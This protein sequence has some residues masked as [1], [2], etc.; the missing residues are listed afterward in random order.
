MSRWHGI[1]ATPLTDAGTYQFLEA[2]R[3]NLEYLRTRS[4]AS[5]AASGLVSIA[6]FGGVGDGSTIN[7]A[8]FQAAEASVYD[9]IY[10]PHGTYQCSAI[11][12]SQLTKGYWG[13]GNILL[14][15]GTAMPGNVSYLATDP[16][17]WPVQGTTGWFRGESKFGRGEWKIIGPGIRESLTDR[18]FEQT[19]IPH[20]VWFDIYSGHSGADARL[21]AP[22]STGSNVIT[23]T[24][25]HAGMVGKTCVLLAA[26]DV[27]IL[28]TRT[29]VSV[30]P[31][32]ITLDSPPSDNW[33]VNTV[34]STARRTWHGH[35]YVRVRHYGGGDGYGHIVRMQIGYQKTPGQTH[36]FDAAT[37]GQYG[38]DVFF[39]TG[40]S[41]T[42]ATGWE[43]QY[44]D[45]GND[46]A[47]IGQVDS[48]IRDNDTAANGQVWHALYLKSE[49]TKPSDAVLAAAGKWRTVI[50][51]VRADL[52]NFDAPG[53]NANV[54]M[55]MA[56]GQRFVW[57]STA[58]LSGRTGSEEWGAY[59]GNVLGD[60]FLETGN[61]GVSDFIALR[62]N[63][64][65]PDDGRLRI[66]PFAVQANVPILSASYIQAAREII[67]GT[68]SP[69]FIFG[70]GSGVYVWWDGTNIR[71]TK[72]NGASS[73]VIV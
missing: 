23:V 40:S 55:N 34:V 25:T 4:S 57:G 73:V 17:K 33:P 54:V 63:R 6:D 24:G 72:D 39:L 70:P 48:F 62:F 43:S 42:Y 26:I 49:G 41:G 69:Y 19:A 53:D 44:H 31:T 2:V 20:S 5:V 58:S 22:A 71:A 65:A 66:R 8:A 52:T 68:D 21:T 61:D 16:V 12:Q 28:D 46:V 18:Y 64:A 9:E 3:N 27:G 35:T 29:I 15:D 7:D 1:P 14:G 32:T 36:P 47:V 59:M 13:P 45:Q 51:T 56:I 60:M 50:D 37:G 10:L 11:A 38:G 30:T 67:A